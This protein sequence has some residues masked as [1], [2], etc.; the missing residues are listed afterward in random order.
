MGGRG[1]WSRNTYTHNNSDVVRF[2]ILPAIAIM[3][4]SVRARTQD[5]KH[6]ETENETE[7]RA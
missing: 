7:A 6:K 5:I 1:N 4:G 2:A 3:N